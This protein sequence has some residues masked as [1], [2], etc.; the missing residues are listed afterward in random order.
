MPSARFVRATM[1]RALELAQRLGKTAVRVRDVPG[2]LVNLLGRAYSL[3]RCASSTRASLRWRRFA[4]LTTPPARRS[5][6][7]P[8]SDRR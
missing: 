1:Q 6:Q 4:A 5:I 2:F 8:V 7:K 3:G